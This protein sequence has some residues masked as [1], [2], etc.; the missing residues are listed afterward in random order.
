M[1]VLGA[2]ALVPRLKALWKSVFADTDRYIDLFFA[3]QYRPDE[4]LADMEDGLVRAML[5]FPRY[6]LRIDGRET[7]AGYVCGAATRPEHRSQ[8]LM[9]A[10]L[11]RAH[12][13]MARRGDEYSVLI[14]ADESL[15][16][17]YARFGYT[18]FF[19]R[20][21]SDRFFKALSGKGSGDIRLRA[22]DTKTLR[23]LYGALSARWPCAVLQDGRRLAMLLRFYP[24]SDNCGQDDRAYIIT[25][26]GEPAGWMF[27]SYDRDADGGR[28]LIQELAG[29]VDAD[30]A[31]AALIGLCPAAQVRIEGPFAG[32]PAFDGHRL[33]GMLKPLKTPQ[34][35]ISALSGYMNMMLD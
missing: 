24:G 4:T 14:P 34:A 9:A 6:R 3:H 23:R 7:F 16:G 35:H 22:A 13:E 21:R 27:C 1:T 32:G 28:W 30:R 17:Y 33:A 25:R 19:R 2:P 20:G 10:L 29:T 5:F 18:P 15:Y 26:S 31:A 12:L 8:G 11:E